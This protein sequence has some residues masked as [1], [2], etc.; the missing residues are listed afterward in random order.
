[1]NSQSGDFGFVYNGANNWFSRAVAIIM[2]SPW[3][4][5]FT[6]IGKMHGVP[7]VL[8]TSDTEVVVNRLDRYLDGRPIK[9]YR[10]VNVTTA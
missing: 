6:C 9:L 7:M 8:E 5:S 1:M 4:H 10:I 3:T 2:G